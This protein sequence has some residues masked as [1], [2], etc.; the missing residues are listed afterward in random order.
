MKHETKFQSRS[1]LCLRRALLS[2]SLTGA[3]AFCALTP[4][5]ADAAPPAQKQSQVPGYYRMQVGAFEVTAL[6]DGFLPIDL[7]G[8]KGASAKDM[9]KLYERM[10]LTNPAPG[11]VNAFLVHTGEQLILVDTGTSNAF[12]P[13]LGAI[14]SNLRASGYEPAQVDLVLLTHLHPDHVRG[15]LT[16]E[17]QP[18]FP[19]AVVRAAQAD[20]D[21]W[22]DE[23]RA[24]EAPEAARPL[25]QMAREAV[26]PYAA[27]GRFKT[28]NSGEVLA[29][30]VSV[31]P[32]PG[33][34]PG[35]SGYLF[36]SKEQSLLVWGDIVHN[37]ALQFPRPEIA[38]EF[39]VDSPKAIA[40]RKRL[41]ADVAK[42]KH[43]VAGAHLP[44]PGLGHVRA[45]GK[46]YT[47]VPAQFGPVQ[48]TP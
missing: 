23:K 44:F 41:L 27:A 33:H 16:P 21:Y 10:F 48:S 19:N 13:T 46:G 40:T 17:G 47:W 42:S 36:T 28:F 5:A 7:K 22:L 6:Y 11:A 9:E 15:L 29:G 35:H 25:F 2:L 1:R 26:A 18:L 37:L 12:G 14:P 32:A 43:W 39:D 30:G 45:E 4:G 8:Y 34:T 24:N 31:T 38:V 20:A 3:A